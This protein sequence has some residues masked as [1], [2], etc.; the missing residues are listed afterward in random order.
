M[1][2][3][4]KK[5]ILLLFE[6]RRDDCFIFMNHDRGRSPLNSSQTSDFLEFD[7][8]TAIYLW[9][10]IQVFMLTQFFSFLASVP[11]LDSKCGLRRL[12]LDEHV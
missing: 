5:T 1:I 6:L 4:S 10:Q 7:F 11:Q 3:N 12:A 2:F 9:V 8:G